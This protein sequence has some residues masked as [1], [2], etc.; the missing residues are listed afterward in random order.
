M[1]F[2][3]SLARSPLLVLLRI[4]SE[5][6]IVSFD[7]QLAL[8]GFKRAETPSNCTALERPVRVMGFIAFTV[9]VR[10]AT[11]VSCIRPEGALLETAF[12]LHS[13][14]PSA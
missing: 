7:A 2:S 9:N 6:T 11:S 12:T 5:L 3:L 8:C 4:N 10:T 14:C 13:Y 1:P